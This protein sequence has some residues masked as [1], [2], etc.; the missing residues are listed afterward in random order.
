MAEKSKVREMVRLIAQ[1]LRTH[2]TEKWANELRDFHVLEY[3]Y[4]PVIEVV[5]SAQIKQGPRIY[6]RRC[7]TERMHKAA[8]KHHKQFAMTQANGIWE[9]LRTIYEKHTDDKKKDEDPNTR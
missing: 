8:G 3:P 5:L 7:V 4:P 6:S 2:P 9:G 1:T